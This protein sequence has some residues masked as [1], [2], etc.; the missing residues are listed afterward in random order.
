M[1]KDILTTGPRL[2][3]DV[4]PHFTS[5]VDEGEAT[6]TTPPRLYLF[7]CGP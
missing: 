1:E 4:D 6:S 3:V 2:L 5:L 7:T